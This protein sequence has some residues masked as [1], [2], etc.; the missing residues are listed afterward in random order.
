M[1]LHTLPHYAEALTIAKFKIRQYIQMTYSPNLMF[2]K[3]SRY[4]VY[5]AQL[6]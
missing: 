2:A 1:L 4:T 6:I 3:V 5:G